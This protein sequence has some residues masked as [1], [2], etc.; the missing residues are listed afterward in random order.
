M[1]HVYRFYVPPDVCVADEVRLPAEE[2]HHAL[3]VVRVRVGDP[4]VVFDGCGREL[5]GTVGN[6]TRRDVTITVT[7]ERRTPAPSKRL[8]LFQAWLHR[9][10]P[11]E[12]LIRRATELGVSR[13]LFFRAAHSERFS[14]VSKRLQR[15][16]V[17]TCKQCGRV[18]LPTFDIAQDLKSA[19]EASA[20]KLLILA[21]DLEP[22]PLRAVVGGDEIGL[23]VGPEGDFSQAELDLALERGASPISLGPGTFRSE[24]AA[25]LAAALVLYEWGL[26]AE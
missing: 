8:T 10:K 7:E 12:E 16:A 18:W 6:V 19:L 14:R 5:L 2:A 22:V 25:A 21:K 1:P 9:E 17:E 3:H 26:L 20:S 11:L 15:V 13:L 23:I 4:A 24:V